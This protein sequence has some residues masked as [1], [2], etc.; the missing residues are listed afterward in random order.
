MCCLEF[1]LVFWACHVR[2]EF[3]ESQIFGYTNYWTDTCL[4]VGQCGAHKIASRESPLV[5]GLPTHA[6]E[7]RLD[8]SDPTEIPHTF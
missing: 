4:R 5:Q 2:V 7:R 8:G 1:Q 3:V 6:A